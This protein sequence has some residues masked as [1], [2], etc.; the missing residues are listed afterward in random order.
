MSLADIRGDLQ[1]HTTASD[2]HT[3]V[4]EMAA[5]AKKLGYG[6]ILIT[7]HS[8]AVTVAHGLDDKRAV[9]NIRRIKAA[10]EKVKGIE[11]WAGAELIF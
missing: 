4:E 2:G 1:M 11:I 3:S 5:A 10:R 7:D 9:E 8:K 6:Y